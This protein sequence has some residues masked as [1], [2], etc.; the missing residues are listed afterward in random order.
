[1][2][3]RAPLSVLS[4]G[5]NRVNSDRRAAAHCQDDSSKIKKVYN[6]N[7]AVGLDSQHSL[8]RPPVRADA[9]IAGLERQIDEKGQEML[10]ARNEGAEKEVREKL[11]SRDTGG[12]RRTVQY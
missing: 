3:Q 7:A 5:N 11:S 2:P 12:D 4:A 1:M 8:R 9:K 10:E 6:P